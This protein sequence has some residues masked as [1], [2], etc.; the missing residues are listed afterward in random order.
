MVEEDKTVEV[1]SIKTICPL[2]HKI[3][4][5]DAK[6]MANLQGKK[7]LI[8]DDKDNEST[9]AYKQHSISFYNSNES[10]QDLIESSNSK[11]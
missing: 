8:M 11:K 3:E 2:S 6:V 4:A 5:M 10:S 7:G 9:A 1:D